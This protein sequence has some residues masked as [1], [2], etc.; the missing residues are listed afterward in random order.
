M[1]YFKNSIRT[2]PAKWVYPR[3]EL[4]I[5]SLVADRNADVVATWRRNGRCGKQIVRNDQ[6]GRYLCVNRERIYLDEL[7]AAAPVKGVCV[8]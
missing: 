5:L 7:R 1:A 6:Y 3:L 4:E 8:A 2:A